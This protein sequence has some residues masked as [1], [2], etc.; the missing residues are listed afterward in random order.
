MESAAPLDLSKTAEILGIS[1]ASVRNW[2]KHGYLMPIDD[3]GRLF[4]CD[5]VLEVKEAIAS[6]RLNRLKKRANKTQADK[7]FL[8][9]EYVKGQENRKNIRELVNYITTSRI[10]TELA[11]FILAVK[12]FREKGDIYSSDL[13]RILGFPAAVFKRKNVYLELKSF[14]RDIIEKNILPQNN[15]HESL[16]R[17]FS[18][19][20]AGVKDF[21]GVVYQ[22][23][24]QEGT[25]AS[26]GSYFTPP[27]IVDRMI[28]ENVRPWYKVLDPCCGT[29]QFLLTFAEYLSD[30]AC[31]WGLDC[32]RTAV[33]IAR[34]NLLLTCSR[35][36]KPN[37]YCV[38]TLNDLDFRDS[39]VLPCFSEDEFDFIATNPPWGAGLNKKTL[40]KLKKEFPEV[41]SGE[42]FSFFLRISLQLLKNKGVLSFLLPESFLNIKLH[43]DIR[44][45]ILAKCRIK[46][47][48]TLGRVFKNV[49][50][51]AIILEVEKNTP[52]QSS[53]VIVKLPDI[54]YKIKQKRFQT[55]KDNTFDILIRPEDETIISKVYSVKHVNLT[56]NAEWAL[57]IVTGDNKKYLSKE[58]KEG[59]EPVFRGSDVCRYFFKEPSCYIRYTPEKFQ[60]SAPEEKYRSSQKL[61]Y[62]FISNKLVFAY[63]NKGRLTLNSANI[64]IPKLEGYPAKII[65]ALFNSSLYQ[66]IYCKKFNTVKVLRGNLEQLPLPLWPEPVMEHIVNLVDGIIEGKD[67]I[68]KLDDYILDQ[69]GLS[70]EERVYIKTLGI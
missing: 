64:L 39:K 51:P 58:W 29:G 25:K 20:A 57:G 35:D 61:V 27:D 49:L 28:R 44:K 10:D 42:S 62:R 5:Q 31:I 50:S 41:N 45:T 68:G 33:K 13:R 7:S 16:E 47:I 52:L 22:S 9:A 18:W 48:E 69:F 26:R 60:Q 38:N 40:T 3:Q 2:V 34:L 4:A 46:T 67:M 30:P 21:L 8:P 53:E 11:I 43:Q 54:Q 56:N 12:L 70:P 32:D 63:D 19:P 37:I 66:Y 55:T 59:Y 23:L 24:I 36:F 1:E 6:G 14:Y 15:D 17:L 65:M